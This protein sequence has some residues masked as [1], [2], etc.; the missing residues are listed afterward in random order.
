MEELAISQVQTMMMVPWPEIA[1]W[2]AWFA[3]F[4]LM[5]VGVALD[6]EI[7]EW[8]ALA[9]FIVLSLI[10]FFQVYERIKARCIRS[11]SGTLEEG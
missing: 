6:N 1:F 7:A 10:G 5:V 9:I 8:A 3:G 2:T 11:P 4:I